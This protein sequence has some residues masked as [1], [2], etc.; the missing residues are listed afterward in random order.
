M[1]I[2]ATAEAHRLIAGGQPSAVTASVTDDYPAIAARQRESRGCQVKRGGS[3]CDCFCRRPD[4]TYKPCPT[5]FVPTPP[6]DPFAPL[7]ARMAELGIR[8]VWAK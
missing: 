6:A 5:P 8:P 1:S 7:R 2:S 4:G 3:P